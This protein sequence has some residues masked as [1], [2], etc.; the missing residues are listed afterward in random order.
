MIKK[1]IYLSI[2]LLYSFM[3]TASAYTLSGYVSNNSVGINGT[4]VSYD[5]NLTYSNITGYYIFLNLSGIATINF[6]RQPEYYPNSTS[7]NMDSDKILN[8]NLIKK[9]TGTISGCVYVFGGVNPCNI[10]YN[11]IESNRIRWFF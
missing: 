2:I 1:I 4:E 9:P 3:V 8:V 10:V 5:L 7:V 11:I 6:S